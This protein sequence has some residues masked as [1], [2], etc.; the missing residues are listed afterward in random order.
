MAQLGKR[1]KWFAKHHHHDFQNH[2]K[3]LFQNVKALFS[4][5]M[6]AEQASE[7]IPAYQ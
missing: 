4:S 5:I 3:V 2:G 6:P 1:C 7:F